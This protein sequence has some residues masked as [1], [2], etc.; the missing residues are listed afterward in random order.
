MSGLRIQLS[1]RSVQGNGICICVHS[2]DEKGGK[3][4]KD[5]GGGGGGKSGGGGR[6][7]GVEGFGGTL[8]DDVAIGGV[9]LKK[10]FG[11]GVCLGGQRRKGN[12]LS[13]LRGMN[14]LE[15]K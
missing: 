11:G 4:D 7:G 15:N 5:P 13:S 12:E 9:G 6:G 14:P 10:H 1:G 2:P 3:Q 8:Q